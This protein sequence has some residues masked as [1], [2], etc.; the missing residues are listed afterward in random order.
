MST[1]KTLFTLCTL[2]F[3]LC[4]Q[5]KHIAIVIDD[6]GYHKNDLTALHLP[7]GVSFSI[8]PH[9]PYGAQF[10][11]LAQQQNKELLLHAPMES[12]NGNPLGPGA[13]TANMSKQQF[14]HTLRTALASLPP[15][16]GVNNH[17]GS[18]LTQ[19]A[20]PMNWTMEVLKKQNLY[21]LDSKTTPKSQA[22]HI[23]QQFG[24]DNLARHVFLDNIP[25]QKQLN[26]RLAQLK[27]I[28]E[29][30]QFAVGIAHPYPETLTFL[31]HALPALK[32]QGY[33]LLPLSELLK[34]KQQQRLAKNTP[35]NEQNTTLAPAKSA[36]V[37]TN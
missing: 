34:A 27:R 25:S 13:L 11:K 12:L 7:A 26:F 4:V 28:A 5:A 3:S 22:Q 35:H 8:L 30:H 32:K 14:Q 20:T 36:S 9:T 18:L 24:V 2:L 33:T 19:Q 16:K 15:V 29:K 37:T 31:A 6:I 17:M 21:F 1:S 23:A 10:A